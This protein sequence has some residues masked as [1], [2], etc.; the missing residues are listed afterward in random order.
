MTEFFPAFLNDLLYDPEVAALIGTGSDLKAMLAFEVALGEAAAKNG[1][2]PQDH[3]RELA[4]RQA[5]SRLIS[6][7]TNLYPEG[8]RRHPRLRPATARP[9]RR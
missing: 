1:F 2:I 6:C 5:H 4:R 3:A 7:A 9:C 8:R